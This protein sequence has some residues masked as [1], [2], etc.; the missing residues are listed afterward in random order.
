M[1][2]KKCV[3]VRH[4]AHADLGC[5]EAEL[6]RLG[7]EVLQLD[8]GID[9]L[10]PLRDADLAIILGGDF[11]V[12]D[13]EDFPVIREELGLL[14]ARLDT[15]MPTLGV[16]LGLQLMAAA[17]GA[18]VASGTREF[19]WVRLR[20]TSVGLV[21]PMRRIAGTPMFVWHG[22]EAQL[23]DGAVLL[24]S[25]EDV[26]V[27]AFSYGRSLAVQFHPEVDPATFERWILGNVA[28]LRAM[29]VDIPALREQ[30]HERGPA[31]VF[32]SRALLRDYVAT[33]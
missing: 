17:L 14:K 12:G 27:H 7:Y 18:P 33:I 20:P 4:L 10:A 25:S 24:A 22:D 29:N 1:P 3:V 15:D 26:A 13:I 19:G 2:S 11:S 21:G 31:A 32:A 28:A 5:W 6:P 9:D 23:P 16:C 30:M 8:A